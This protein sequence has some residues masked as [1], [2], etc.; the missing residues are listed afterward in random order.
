MNKIDIFTTPLYHCNIEQTRPLIPKLESRIY[1]VEKTS[2][3]V[4]K[5]NAGGFQSDYMNQ[6]DEPAYNKLLTILKPEI[7]KVVNDWYFT[8]SNIQ[9]G[10]CWYNINRK[11]HFNWSH[12]HPDGEFACVFYVKC[13]N[14]SD[15]VFDNPDQIRTWKGHIHDKYTPYTTP[16][17]N[18]SPKTNDFLM[19]PAH[20][21]HKVEVNNSDED[22]LSLSFNLAI[23]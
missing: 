6:D 8:G 19:F 20:I 18:Y 13:N 5:S 3:S 17:Y 15:I 21:L 10:Y 1:E 14:E 11:G 2:K 12:S 7:I 22:R 16:G 9:V 23:S 4:V